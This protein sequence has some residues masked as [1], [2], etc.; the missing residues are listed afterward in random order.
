MCVRTYSHECAL[1]MVWKH[2]IFQ[3]SLK[4]LNIKVN[5]L[6]KP[7]DIHNYNTRKNDD[8]IEPKYKLKKIEMSIYFNCIIVLKK[9][10]S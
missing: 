8:F 3:G 5:I 2:N 6:L 7:S 4:Y 9:D 1:H 10:S